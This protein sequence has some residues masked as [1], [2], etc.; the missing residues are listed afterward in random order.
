LLVGEEQVYEWRADG[1][2][3]KPRLLAEA[4]NRQDFD[5]QLIGRSQLHG[6]YPD[7]LYAQ[8]IRTHMGDGSQHRRVVKWSQNRWQKLQGPL[9]DSQDTVEIVESEK[10]TLA[11][12]CVS[13][14]CFFQPV[15]GTPLVPRFTWQAGCS[16]RMASVLAAEVDDTGTLH[17]LGNECS[18]GRVL[19][20]RW[21]KGKTKSQVE[22][23]SAIEPRQDGLF[24]LHVGLGIFEGEPWVW[25]VEWVWGGPSVG[26]RVLTRRTGGTWPLE[27]LLCDSPV[28]AFSI[29]RGY[30]V[31]VC[32][33]LLMRPPGADWVVAKAE[34][35][36]VLSELQLVDGRLLL[37][38][39]EGLWQFA[40]PGVPDDAPKLSLNLPCPGYSVDLGI[41][42]DLARARKLIEPLGDLRKEMVLAATSWEEDKLFLVA[43]DQQT[44]FA[45]TNTLK[46]QSEPKCLPGEFRTFATTD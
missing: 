3:A 5:A 18:T 40:P 10:G 14:R 17:V 21:P 44:A 43:P 42:K 34:V 7:N 28:V 26:Q 37:R 24:P 8:I 6:R 23:L 13:K 15:S 41:N 22:L 38:D 2:V 12:G 1:I 45:A 27:E 29:W 25:G 4:F 33:K 19:L 32:D 9:A 16:T 11:V 31:A 20:E 46:L 30:H 35:T 36:D 39:S